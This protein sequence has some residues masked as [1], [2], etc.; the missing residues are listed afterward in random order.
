MK[1]R[2]HKRHRVA[3]LRRRIALRE[4]RRQWDKATDDLANELA[5]FILAPGRMFRQMVREITAPILQAVVASG[6]LPGSTFSGVTGTAIP[7]VN[8]PALKGEA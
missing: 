2:H 1:L 5:E 3:R 4:L 7:P 8:H 6:G